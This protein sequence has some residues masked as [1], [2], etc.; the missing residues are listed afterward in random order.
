MRAAAVVPALVAMLAF[1][2]AAVA[3]R[4]Q[5]HLTRTGH[6]AAHNAVIRRS[7]LPAGTWT[8][9]V[10]KPT[11]DSSTG[12]AGFTPKQSDLV[13]IGAAETEWKSDVVQFD[14]QA[15]VL[16]TPKM[17]RLDWKRTVQT[18]KVMPCLRHNLVQSLS[19][20]ERLSF[21]TRLPVARIAPRVRLYRSVVVFHAGKTPTPILIDSLLIGKGRTEITLTTTALYASRK[22]ATRAEI[23]LGRK[24][25]RRAD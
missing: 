9:T 22:A 23:T 14:S 17:V 5:V 6:R 2:A 24:L 7:D 4:E 11:I 8:G 13:L 21:V 19:S 16:R 10:K 1:T 18:P 12:C 15:Q 3:D 20:T 25:A